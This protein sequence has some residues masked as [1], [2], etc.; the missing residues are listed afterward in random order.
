M[1]LATLLALGN[2]DQRYKNELVGLEAIQ[3]TPDFSVRVSG[4]DFTVHFTVLPATAY[5]VEVYDLTGKRVAF[6]GHQQS[7]EREVSFTFVKSLP[8]GLYI[9]RLTAGKQVVAKKFQI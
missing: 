1:L 9:V 7:E 2:E 6:W 8:A 5:T 4:Q 3:T